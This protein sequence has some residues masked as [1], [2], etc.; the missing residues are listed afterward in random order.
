MFIKDQ[1]YSVLGCDRS[2]KWTR[3]GQTRSI[4]ELIVFNPD[5]EAKSK[6]IG[7][8]K[9]KMASPPP[10]FQEESEVHLSIFRYRPIDHPKSSHPP[11]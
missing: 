4:S 2:T 1:I 3:L 6:N 7:P 8:K 10:S 11:L 9:E 5:M